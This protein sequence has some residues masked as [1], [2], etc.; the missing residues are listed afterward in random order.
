MKG[1]SKSKSKLI[2]FGNLLE[3]QQPDIM[4]VCET[5]LKKTVVNSELYNHNIYKGYRLDRE[6]IRGGGVLLLI[7]KTLWSTER[8]DLIL[9][10]NKHNEIVAAEVR[11]S[12]GR[13]I[14]VISVYRSQT[15][16]SKEFLS[17]FEHVL[18]AGCQDNINEFLILGDFNYRELTWVE[19]LDTNVP[20]HC[21]DLLSI[22]NRFGLQQLN[23][24]PSTV[25]GNILDLILT[26]LPEPTTDVISE[27][28]P[29]RSDHY[30]L[31][32]YISINVNKVKTVPRSTYNF[33]R[34]NYD[35]INRDLGTMQ[36]QQ[37]Q[38]LS[39][40]CLWNQF[41]TKVL[42]TIIAHVPT[43][44]IKNKT[45]AP[46]IDMDVIR[47]SHKK[48]CALH[49][50]QKSNLDRHWAKFKRLRNRL[51]NLVSAK[52]WDYLR[53]I[54]D[55]LSTKPK[56]FWNLLG[57]KSKSKSSPTHIIVGNKEVTDPHM[58]ATYFNQ[59][60]QS[61]FS[62]WSDREVPEVNVTVD[63]NLSTIVLTEE[64]VAAA[65]KN[66]DSSKAPGPDN[67]P[68]CIY[69]DC[70]ETLTASITALFNY[71]LTIAKLPHEW[72][73]ANVVP[74]FKKGN[75][76]LTNNYRPI[77][78]LPVISKILERCIYNR[79][80]TYL[81]PKLTSMQHGFLAK[82]STSTQLL[83]VL[84]K[85]NNILDS[86]VQTD[87][88]YFD[89]SKAFDSVPH[90][91]LLAKLTSFGINGSLLAWISDYLTNREQRV[92]LDGST[93][94]WL[95]VTSGVPQG[96]ILGP[97]LFLLYINDLPTACLNLLSVQSL[98]MT[99]RSL[100]PFVTKKMSTLSK[101]I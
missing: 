49:K 5:W 25:D 31:E 71:S 30:L 34:A 54:T 101:R 69:K 53:N 11:P 63:P 48:V 33:R 56:M 12:K 52:R 23:Y 94:E 86:R 85:I 38:E 60:F 4:A 91:P 83:T 77:S 100:D 75:P 44:T 20:N 92:T 8:K 28:Y 46:W 15:D 93:S 26:N 6:D 66:V 79:I 88:I 18:Q 67:I 99:Q 3:V 27:T 14:L 39:R 96:S 98:L 13:K 74:V 9:P 41:K 62:T 80:I 51:K 21:K 7:K 61:I 40:D 17:N 42:N 32:F 2:D 68:T 95:P 97:L 29:Y 55:Q 50:A 22:T 87:I 76:A 24:N 64:E 90:A 70:A 47:L 37:D 78:L 43:V 89:L 84:S 1:T 73:R 72:K 35:N 58:K 10:T 57:S 19:N 45:S 81:R 59:F 36:L 65:L 82:C 16:P